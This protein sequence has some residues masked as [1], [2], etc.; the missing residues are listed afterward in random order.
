MGALSDNLHLADGLPMPVCHFKR[1]YFS[2]L[3]EGVAAYGY[4]ASKKETY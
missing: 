1:A 2:R 4:C 3:F